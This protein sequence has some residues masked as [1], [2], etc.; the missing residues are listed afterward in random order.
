M[1]LKGFASLLL[2]QLTATQEFNPVNAALLGNQV[3]QANGE[4]SH[5]SYLGSELP[6]KIRKKTTKIG[7][8]REGTVVLGYDCK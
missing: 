1:E 6:T 7:E 8:C 3:E 4:I 5:L 2:L